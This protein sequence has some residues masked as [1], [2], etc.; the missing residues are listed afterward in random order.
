ME[1]E[2]MPCRWSKL[3][4]CELSMR[5]ENCL[6]QAR[7]SDAKVIGRSYRKNALCFSCKHA[8]AQAL[9]VLCSEGR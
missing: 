2:M 8:K 7:C 1:N 9:N 6:H 3:K 5:C 4:Q